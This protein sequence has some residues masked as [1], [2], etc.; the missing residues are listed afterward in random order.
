MTQIPCA[1]NT[2]SARWTWYPWAPS[3]WSLSGSARS[4]RW[5]R[6]HAR[7]HGFPP[8]LP[9]GVSPGL[10]R[11][12]SLG[13]S[14]GWSFF[15]SSFLGS[16]GLLSGLAPSFESGAGLGV[17]R[18]GDVLLPRLLARPAKPP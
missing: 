9:G 13:R 6:K 10:G 8:K 16:A 12:G 5:E 7:L 17:E 14:E 4:N 18:D 3:R 2:R 11:K 15:D 1:R